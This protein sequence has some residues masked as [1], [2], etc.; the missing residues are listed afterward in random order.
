MNHDAALTII[1]APAQVEAAPAVDEHAAPGD[2]PAPNVDAIAP[3]APDALGNARAINQAQSGVFVATE[4]ARAGIVAAID[5]ATRNLRLRVLDPSWTA[6]GEARP[7][8]EVPT[9]Y[10]AV[11]I[12]VDRAL[13]DHNLHEISVIRDAM[14]QDLW[15]GL[16]GTI[17]ATAAIVATGA[18]DSSGATGAATGATG[19]IGAMD[20]RVITRT[21]AEPIRRSR[22][23]R[24]KPGPHGHRGGVRGGDGYDGTTQD[25]P[26]GS[27]GMDGA[28]T[29]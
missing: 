4:R 23:K 16:T 7:D 12:A 25:E 14:V 22:V 19:A 3:A 18:T 15:A 29:R 24:G 10:M 17:G 11:R 8:E 13:R 26:E 9:E 2:A 5:D 20:D 6:A 21:H 1:G 28:G 27:A